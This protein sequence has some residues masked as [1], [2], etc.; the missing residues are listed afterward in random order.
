MAYSKPCKYTT[1]F[2]IMGLFELYE[3]AKC[4]DFC[5][6]EACEYANYLSFDILSIIIEELAQIH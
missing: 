5:Y 4:S 2:D 3:Y 1:Y 6:T